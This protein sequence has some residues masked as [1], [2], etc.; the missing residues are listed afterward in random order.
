MSSFVRTQSATERRLRQAAERA[1]YERELAVAQDERELAMVQQRIAALKTGPPTEPAAEGGSGGALF[2]PSTCYH[3]LP[4]ADGRLQPA[5]WCW[6][7]KP[8]WRSWETRYVVLDGLALRVY[9]SKTEFGGSPGAWRGSSIT[10][11]SG[12]AVAKA[13]RGKHGPALQLQHA[14]YQYGEALLQFDCE[15][16][17]DAMHA[18][19]T[20]VA[21]G[22]PWDSARP[23]GAAAETGRSEALL[24]AVASQQPPPPR[25]GWPSVNM[26]KQKALYNVSLEYN[27]MLSLGG[28]SYQAF[29]DEDRPWWSPILS[30]GEAEASP[31]TLVLVGAR[32]KPVCL[33]C[34]DRREPSSRPIEHGL[35]SCILLPRLHF[36]VAGCV[37]TPIGRASGSTH[38]SRRR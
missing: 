5:A 21:A 31:S 38:S 36:G 9:A 16:T 8:K 22:R 23:E 32:A 27:K 14:A 24:A 20:N 34:L 25:S 33:F 2:A 37:A 29:H 13:P 30:L 28:N 4:A 19:C 12:F 6:K 18:A 1:T 35:T 7:Q 15:A 11:L 17:R 26:F 3:L 10:D